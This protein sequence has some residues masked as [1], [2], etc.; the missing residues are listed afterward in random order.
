MPIIF[1][2]SFV[3]TLAASVKV[4]CKILLLH[5][6]SIHPAMAADP[7]P[8]MLD[9]GRWQ[10]W[11]IPADSSTASVQE[12]FA[13]DL[14]ASSYGV[15]WIVYYFDSVAG[16][17]VNPGLDGVIPQGKG[18]WII[19]I[20]GASISIDLPTTIASAATETSDACSDSECT[21]STVSSQ[22]GQTTYNL[23]GSALPGA[24]SVNNIRFRSLATNGA[25]RGGCPLEV[26][27][28]GQLMS[29]P[30]WHYD[31]ASNAYVDLSLVGQILP[32]QSVW[33]QTGTALAGA[34]ADLL[35][36]VNELPPGPSA[37]RADAS[38]F[39]AQTTFGP[40]TSAIN[41]LIATD[42]SRW[43]N[44]QFNLPT[45][46]MLASFDALQAANP[47]SAPSRD[48]VFE[49][50]WKQAV[51]ADDQLRQRLAFALSQLFVI[52]LREGAVASFPRG[53]ADYY[54]VLSEGA[55]GNF[56]TLLENVSLHPMMG[57]YLS[58]LGNAKGDSATGQVPDE[59]FAREIMQL[60][61]IGLY[62]LNPD[63]SV[64]RA[65]DNSPIETYSNSDV[66]GLAKVFT[67]YSWHGPDTSTGRFQGW[68]SVPDREIQ[69][70]Q[71]YPQF[72]S[73]AQKRFLG[74][75]INAQSV[76]NPDN[77]LK[78]ALDALFNHPNVGPF[79]G[80]Q[81]IQRLVTSNPSRA[82]VR[83][84]TLAFNDNGEGVR[85]DMRAVIRAILLDPE[86]RDRQFA[87][88][89]GHGRL[90]EPILRLAHWMRSFEASAP[91][92]RYE[93]FATD[94]PATN[95]GMTVMRSP[96]VFNF[97]RPGYVPPNTPIAD[98]GLVSPEMQI[99]HETSIAGY[100]NS[101][102]N[103]VELGTGSNNAVASNY[104]EAVALSA[105]TQSLIN[106]VDVLLLHGAMSSALANNL[107][108]A[109]DTIAVASGGNRA[110]SLR[111]RAQLAVYLTMASPEYIVLK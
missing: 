104:T 62:E 1:S 57:S 41:T 31:S 87:T 2:Q 49:S 58:H 108:A 75:V 29:A 78:I 34:N 77:D 109:I 56:R 46:S 43:I 84:V 102:L 3:R 42:Y 74:T 6:L 12:I 9:S 80:K 16:S 50:F 45:T 69:P 82:Y 107:E 91:S 40:T 93:L 15:E 89:P 68:I 97:Y 85:G 13:D 90:R 100:L 17:Y 110:Q 7:P 8:A 48:W 103:A 96:S 27:V 99:T 32:W 88:D 20:T 23:I 106:H 51:E 95:I 61:T 35:F 65:A 44:T 55:F 73:V 22:G 79:I 11:V 28:A 111:R 76:A 37:E 70:M 52:S 33:M 94:D 18:F 14:P 5:A 21:V 67:G 72:H 63:G 81:L 25:C 71:P 47:A 53:V 10:Q 101:L 54:T 39:L 66:Q 26:A 19:Q 64:K 4:V 83:R 38:R 59:N 92:G 105:D 36:P 30:L 24:T 86:A 98:A 60:F